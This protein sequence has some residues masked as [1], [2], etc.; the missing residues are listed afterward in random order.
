SRTNLSLIETS[1][2]TESAAID[3]EV[4]ELQSQLQEKDRA[5]T[6]SRLETLSAVHQI[7]S[8]KETMNRMR[9][10]IER[11]NQENERLHYMMRPLM[12]SPSMGSLSSSKSNS[13]GSQQMC[14][15]LEE[16]EDTLINAL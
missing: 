2:L 4:S 5:L 8:L 10:E 14:D 13:Q 9:E 15:K 3:F 7:E 12:V 16:D 1:S 6:D 11:L